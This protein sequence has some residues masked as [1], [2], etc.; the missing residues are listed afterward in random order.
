MRKASLTSMSATCS[1]VFVLAH[2]AHVDTHSADAVAMTAYVV[3]TLAQW[4][5]SG[6]DA[7][8]EYA[9]PALASASREQS[10]HRR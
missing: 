2:D 5:E 8:A 10:A 9:L 6:V 7:V 1:L 3:R 4:R